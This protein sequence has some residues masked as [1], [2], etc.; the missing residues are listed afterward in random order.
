MYICTIEQQMQVYKVYKATILDILQASTVPMLGLFELCLTFG[1]LR[2]A[3]NPEK[4]G[5]ATC[6]TETFK[7]GCYVVPENSLQISIA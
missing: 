5:N 7:S 6:N 3:Y 1:F 4:P 2:G